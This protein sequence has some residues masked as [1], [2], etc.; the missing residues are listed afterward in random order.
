MRKRSRFSDWSRRRKVAVAIAAGFLLLGICFVTLA[1]VGPT[2]PTLTY[3]NR[4]I[5]TSPQQF[6]T[7]WELW[8]NRSF[9]RYRMTA[10]YAGTYPGIGG[11]CRQEVEIYQ[12][13]V[14]AVIENTCSE[15]WSMT[16]TDIF[17]LIQHFVGTGPTR[18]EASDGCNYYIVDAVYHAELGYPLNIENRLIGTERRFFKVLSRSNY[19]C[20]AIL[21]PLYRIE[22]ESLVPLY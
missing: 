10:T 13:R 5:E 20:L 6:A 19:S 7:S 17:E 11:G 12:E 14:V 9:S 21:P 1:L 15:T 2:M 4:G 22:I 16:V 18:P 3:K 8:R